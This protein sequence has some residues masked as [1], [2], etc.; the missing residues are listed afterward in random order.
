MH[1]DMHKNNNVRECLTLE[2]HMSLTLEFLQCRPCRDKKII[3]HE[4]WC[5][6]SERLPAY[7][8]AA[9]LQIMVHP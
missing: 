3:K 7:L 5:D 8:E 6:D 9:I 2:K 1:S 4:V